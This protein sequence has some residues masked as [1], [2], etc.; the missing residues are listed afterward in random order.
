M[1]DITETPNL[2]SFAGNPVIFEGCSDNFILS[3]GAYAYFELVVSGVDTTIGHSFTLQFAG[4]TLVFKTAGVTGYDGYLFGVGYPGQSFNDFA[5]NIYKC[6]IE[7]YY[8]QKYFT[9]ALDPI[10]VSQRK[11]ILQARQAGTDCSVVLS[12]VGVLGV[13][14]GV[15]APGTDDVYQD[16]FSILCLVR[17]SYNN[18]IGEDIKPS[19]SIG[20]ASFDIS[21]YLSSKFATWQMPRFEL[22]ELT[23]NVKVH[24]WDYLLKYRASF[25]ESIAG[26]VKGLRPDGWKYALAG[27]LNHELLTS[28]NENN[29]EYFS[30]PANKLKFLTWL[31]TSKNSRSGVLEKLFFL[32]Q[33]NPTGIQYRLVMIITFTDG[34]HK[35]VNTTE[36]KAFAA[37]SVVEFKVGFDHLDLVNAEFGKIVQSWEVFLMDSNDDYLSERRIFYNDNG[38]YENEKVFFYRNSFSAYD[39]FRFLGKHELNLEYERQIGTTIREEKYSFFNA[40]SKQ[41]SAKETESCKANSGWISLQEKNCLR[42]LLL[43]TEAY[44]QINNELFQIVVKSAKITPFLKDG[45]Y[46]YNLEIEYDRSYQNSFF[47][48][49]VPES[50]ANPILVPQLL[51]WDNNEVSFDDME[52]TFDQTTY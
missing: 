47:S 23:G 52:I 21:D 34:T 41:F 4:K 36:Q 22:P 13:G 38:V 32:F 35:V 45:E 25:A 43:S 40:P 18:P 14:Q 3:C 24:G 39:T 17:D 44:E 1:I 2:I 51:T 5:F 37:Y 46:L 29:L 50:S 19:D 42:E 27:G 28:L 20:C 12:N 15:N 11:I 30:I 8:I 10:G 33:D 31:P 16:Y 6:F 48:V 7:N 26:I 49:H 9:I